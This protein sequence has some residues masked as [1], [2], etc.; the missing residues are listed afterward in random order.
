VIAWKLCASMAA[1]DVTDTL[2]L[3]LAASGCT[4]A[5]VRHRPRLLSDNG[6]GY[7]AGDLATWLASNGMEHIRGAPCNRRPRA[8]SSAGTRH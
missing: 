3:E 1:S 8:R 5:R 4:G 7:I 6:P 2:E